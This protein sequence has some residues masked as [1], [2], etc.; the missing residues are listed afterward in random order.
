MPLGFKGNILTTSS[1]A[2]ALESIVTADGTSQPSNYSTGIHS[3]S[4]TKS[5][6]ELNIFGTATTDGSANAYAKYMPVANGTYAVEITAIGGIPQSNSNGPWSGTFS[7]GAG[8]IFSSGG[9]ATASFTHGLSPNVQKAT[10]GAD[11]TMESV[12]LPYSLGNITFSTSTNTKGVFYRWSA[13][14]GGHFTSATSVTFR[15]TA[16]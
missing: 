15:F 1:S 16:T 9:T 3:K 8:K 6:D 13:P 12:T 14:Y 2:V 4:F 10:S 5:K 11:E 7:M